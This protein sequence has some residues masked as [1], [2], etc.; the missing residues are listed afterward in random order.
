MGLR[1]QSLPARPETDQDKHDNRLN[2]DSNDASMSGRQQ[3]NKIGTLMDAMLGES[4]AKGQNE[5][6]NAGFDAFTN[7]FGL[8]FS[9][10]GSEKDHAN[11]TAA[12]NRQ[13]GQDFLQ[14][15]GD[16]GF[17]PQQDKRNEKGVG[18]DNMPL[19]KDPEYTTQ[20][21]GEKTGDGPYSAKIKRE[22]GA[23]SVKYTA[24]DNTSD[25]AVKFKRHDGPI[26]TAM[27]FSTNDSSKGSSFNLSSRNS[28][29][30]SSVSID[31]GRGSRG[32]SVDIAVKSSFSDI[33]KNAKLARK[34]YKS[35]V[36]TEKSLNR[37][38]QPST[39]EKVS[40]TPP[41]PSSDAGQQRAQ[42]Q[43]ALKSQ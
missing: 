24:N 43:P 2:D 4:A 10:Q 8:G 5:H 38:Q 17:L 7:T 12:Y 33:F 34:M 6:N 28:E 16:F 37:G 13:F 21:K 3:Q 9:V 11:K 39:N 15:N 35:A 36:N 42:S 19:V 27:Q 18:G 14:G 40:T 30:N 32:G 25:W 41:K 1:S 23:H 20:L 31:I 22:D 29:K 26:T